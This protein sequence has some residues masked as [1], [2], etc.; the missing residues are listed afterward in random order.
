MLI[1]CTLKRDADEPIVVSM[2][3]ETYTFE[4]DEKGRR[5]AEVWLD[6][7]IECFLACDSLYREVKDEAETPEPATTPPLKREEIMAQLRARNVVFKVTSK[8]EA[9]LELLTAARAA[10][11]AEA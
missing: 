2:S 10:E 7:H 11:V 4:P 6:K 1:E 3:N 5:V 9:L 8:T